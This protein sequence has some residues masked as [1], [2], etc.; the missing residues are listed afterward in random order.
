MAAS[1]T[2]V[3]YPRTVI[4]KANRR[5]AQDNRIPAVLYGPE[6]E[7]VALAIDRHEFEQLMSH[8]SAGSTILELE[9]EG[10]KKPVNAMIREMQTNPIKGQIIHVDFLAVQMDKPV[11]AVVTLRFVNDPAG[12]KAGGILTTSFHEINVEAKPGDLPEAIEVDVA[13]LEV[14]D[15]LHVSDVVPPSGVA[16]LDDPEEVLVSVQAP[17]LEVEEEAVVGEEEALEPELVSG[18]PEE[19]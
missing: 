17:R 12:V 15:S 7:T 10:E 19:E 11:H 3:A 18:T 4:G 8:H 6:R 9:V 2:L 5:L 1:T 16:I 13:S 14:G